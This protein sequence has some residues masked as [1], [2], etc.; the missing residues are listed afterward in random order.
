MPLTRDA[1]RAAKPGPKTQKLYDGGGLYLLVTPG[2]AKGWRFR[3]RYGGRELLLSFGPHPEVSL[4]SARR[5]REAARRLLRAGI[6]PRAMRDR[7][8]A[9]GVSDAE[10]Q[11]ATKVLATR[12]K[13]TRA[14][15]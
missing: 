14:V 1:I 12:A 6:D 2:G 7:V 8:R 13:R 11:E 5:Q 9:A 10:I 4:A 3:Y 15:T